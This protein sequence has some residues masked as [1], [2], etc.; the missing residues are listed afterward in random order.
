[1]SPEY[2]RAVGVSVLRGRAPGE[3]DTPASPPVLAVNEALARRDFPGEDPV[4][5]RISFGVRPGGE[6]YWFQIVGVVT[7]V[8]STEIQTEPAPEIYTSYLQDPFAGMSYVVRSAVEP[9]SLAPAVREA[10]RSV[11][12]AQPVAEFRTLENLVGEAVA[13]PRLNSIL[14]GVFAG[15]ALALAAAGI[16]G[17]MSYAVSQRTHEIGIRIALGAQDRDVLRFVVGQGM[18]LAAAGVGVGLFASFAVTRLMSGLLYGVSPSD[19]ATLVFV[20]LTLLSV[21]LAACLVPARR[22]MKVD[23]MVALRHE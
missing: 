5:K 15:L 23:P 16:Y 11:D 22:A 17:V 13:E 9:E 10:V 3:R 18:V 7:D 12:R 4:G 19:P 14:L 1:V 8:R 20:S 6:P 21:A 2:F